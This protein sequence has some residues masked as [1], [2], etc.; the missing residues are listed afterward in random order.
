MHDREQN[1][2][3]LE[4]LENVV[5]VTVTVTLLLRI[6]FIELNVQL[7]IIKRSSWKM[8]PFTNRETNHENFIYK[9][10]NEIAQNLDD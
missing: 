3:V 4:H 2:M 9:S 6:K 5:N 8:L 1:E 7:R 10:V